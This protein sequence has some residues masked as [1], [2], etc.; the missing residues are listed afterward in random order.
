MDRERHDTTREQP[1]G[2]EQCDVPEGMTL[3]EYRRRRAGREPAERARLRWRR[4]KKREET[5]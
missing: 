1:F 4:P 2:Y 5:R 3:D